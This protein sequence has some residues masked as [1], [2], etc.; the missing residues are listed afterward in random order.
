MTAPNRRKVLQAI[1]DELA[2]GGSI[3]WVF[4]LVDESEHFQDMASA[5][6]VRTPSPSPPPNPATPSHACSTAIGYSLHTNYGVPV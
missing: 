1:E 3:F 4:P 5:H 6:Q 2:A